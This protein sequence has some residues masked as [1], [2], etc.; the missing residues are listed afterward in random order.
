M[1]NWETRLG[2]EVNIDERTN[3]NGQ[4]L[5][6]HHETY[7]EDRPSAFLYG[8]CQSVGSEKFCL[9]YRVV[10]GIVPFGGEKYANVP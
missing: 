4:D 8:N 2:K 7:D 6:L 3:P 10:L 5:F 9:E 1:S